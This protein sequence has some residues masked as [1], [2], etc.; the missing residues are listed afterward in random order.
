MLPWN[1]YTL[2]RMINKA[3][4]NM[5]PWNYHTTKRRNHENTE[6][7]VFHFGGNENLTARSSKRTEIMKPHKNLASFLYQQQNQVS[8]SLLYKKHER[9]ISY[10]QT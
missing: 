7:N 9:D 10:S 6:I 1:Y 2:D 4:A 5:L 3:Q 8:V